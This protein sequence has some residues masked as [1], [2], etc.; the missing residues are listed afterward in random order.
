MRITDFLLHP[1]GIFT[2]EAAADAGFTHEGT[3]F[4]L[5]AWFVF[6]PRNPDHIEVWTKVSLAVFLI[7]VAVLLLF[8]AGQVPNLD[9]VPDTQLCIGDRIASDN[10]TGRKGG[11]A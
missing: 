11:K 10:E 9:S 7:H 2:R 1:I 8:V 3:V 4:G 6:D 5:P